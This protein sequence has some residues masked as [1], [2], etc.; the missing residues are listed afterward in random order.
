MKH[1]RI[2]EKEIARIS[3]EF[4]SVAMAFESRMYSNNFLSEHE[5]LSVI[6]KFNDIWLKFCSH[7]NSFDHLVHPNPFAFQNYLNNPLQVKIY[8]E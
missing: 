7:W 6:E 5:E 1:N 3:L 8:D 2:K 4:Y